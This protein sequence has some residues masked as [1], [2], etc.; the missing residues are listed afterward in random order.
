MPITRVVATWATLPITVYCPASVRADV[1]A[2][3]AP[4]NKIARQ[5][6][7]ALSVNPEADI[8]FEVSRDG[9]TQIDWDYDNAGHLKHVW[10]KV[11]NDHNDTRSLQHEMGHGL[12]FNDHVNAAYLQASVANRPVYPADTPVCDSRRHPNY[13]KYQ[14]VMSYCS[15]GRGWWGRDDQALMELAGYR[16]PSRPIPSRPIRRTR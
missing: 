12:G 4:W 10:I 13:V 2:I 15:W 14:G 8:T 9:W 5:N 1:P 6:I 7:L 16:P 3:I 11:G